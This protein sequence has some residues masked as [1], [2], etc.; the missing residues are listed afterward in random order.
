M[1]A[2]ILL[3]ILGAGYLFNKNTSKDGEDDSI[4]NNL[5]GQNDSYAT[6]YFHESQQ[7]QEHSNSLRDKYETLRIPGVKNINSENIEEYLN[8][9]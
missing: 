8:R 5:S 3:G 1:E 6:D 4:N 9:I 2:T 7:T